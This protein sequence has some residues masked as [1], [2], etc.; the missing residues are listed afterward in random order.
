MWKHTFYTLSCCC[1]Q[2]TEYYIYHLCWINVLIYMYAILCFHNA[3]FIRD[4]KWRKSCNL[5]NASLSHI[6][7]DHISA[8]H[9]RRSYQSNLQ[10]S[11]IILYQLE[12]YWKLDKAC[13]RLDKWQVHH[14]ISVYLSLVLSHYQM[15]STGYQRQGRSHSLTQDFPDLDN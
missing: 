1:T 12:L 3:I 8:V 10:I 4:K 14:F 2:C 7:D 13:T 15:L 9:I 6:S 11:V 5:Q